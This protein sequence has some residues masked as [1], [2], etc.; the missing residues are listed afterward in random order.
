[1]T[2]PFFE[3][4]EDWSNTGDV[5]IWFAR[6]VSNEVQEHVAGKLAKIVPHVKDDERNLYHLSNIVSDLFIDMINNKEI[7]HSPITKRWE[8]AFEVS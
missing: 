3:V 7:R 4:R 2:L 5:D 1:M 6:N 8:R